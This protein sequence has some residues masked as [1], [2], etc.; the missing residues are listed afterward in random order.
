MQIE[1]NTVAAG[2][3]CLAGRISAMHETLLQT[4]PVNISAGGLLPEY[5]MPPLASASTNRPVVGMAAAL[6]HTHAAFKSAASNCG[7]QE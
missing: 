7:A 2:F 6:A 3:A 5:P 1:L 4:L